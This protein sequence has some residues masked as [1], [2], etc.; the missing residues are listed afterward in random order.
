MNDF[1]NK[2]CAFSRCGVCDACIRGHVCT[3]LSRCRVRDSCSHRCLRVSSYHKNSGDNCLTNSDSADLVVVQVPTMQTVRKLAGFHR[4][5]SQ[6][7]LLACSLGIPLVERRHLPM[8]LAVQKT[9]E[10]PKLQFI[11]MPVVVQQQVPMVVTSG[12][13][14][15]NCAEARGDSTGAVLG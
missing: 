12:T 6:T 5:S 10:V 1:S 15:A 11:V 13:H 14:S 7:R 3:G 4:C 8:V 9:I 2:F